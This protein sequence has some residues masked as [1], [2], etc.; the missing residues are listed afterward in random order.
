LRQ[1]DRDCRPL[2]LAA[3]LFA[4]LTTPSA[5][6]APAPS[7]ADPPPAAAAAPTDPPPARPAS[8]APPPGATEPQ[9]PKVAFG[10]AENTFRY[11]DYERAVGLLEALLYPEVKLEEADELRAREWLGASCWFLDDF[12]RSEEEFT[13]LLTRQPGYALDAFYYP[14][15]LI[16]FFEGVREKLIRLKVIP[17]VGAGPEGLEPHP[18]RETVVVQERVVRERSWLVAVLPF[19][20]GQFQN[21]DTTKGIVFLTL[22]SLALATNIAS[23]FV[24]DSLQEKDGFISPGNIDRAREFEIVLYSSLG[25]FGA[26]VIGGLVD[27]LVCFEPRDETLRE[28]EPPTEEPET[29]LRVLPSATGDTLG[30]DMELRF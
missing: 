14:A 3:G 7:P 16:T 1:R 29:S 6:A 13:V 28:L 11:Q 15:A 10:V 2:V 22:E 25:V 30:L 21:G 20:I 9:D 23:Y 26:L 24:I 19:G 8:P 12:Q 18:P 17:P 5:L 4:L 27:A